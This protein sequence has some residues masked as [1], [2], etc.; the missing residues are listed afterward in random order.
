MCALVNKKMEERS[1]LVKWGMSESH[2]V[3]PV[4]T[5]PLLAIYSLLSPSFLFYFM[6]NGSSLLAKKIYWNK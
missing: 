3:L 2:F 6:K 1:L 5:F 4:P